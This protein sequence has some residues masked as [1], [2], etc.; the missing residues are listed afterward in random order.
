VF[1]LS[2]MATA[3]TGKKK[4]NFRADQAAI[5]LLRIINDF[6]DISKMKRVA[7]P[8]P[9]TAQPAGAQG[10]VYSSFTFNKR[11]AACKYWCLEPILVEADAAKLKQVLINVIGNAVK[12]TEQEASLSRRG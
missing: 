7:L 12:F 5:H 10:V 1:V 6:L 2:G 3:M 4:W 8:Y 11:L 9:G